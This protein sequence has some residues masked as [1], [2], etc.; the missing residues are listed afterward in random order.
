MWNDSLVLNAQQCS[1]YWIV[2]LCCLL[3]WSISGHPYHSC[4]HY[5]HHQV[6]CRQS[7]H[8]LQQPSFSA[9]L[10]LHLHLECTSLLL[11]KKVFLLKGKSLAANTPVFKDSQDKDAQ[12]ATKMLATALLAQ[13]DVKRAELDSHLLDEVLLTSGYTLL[14]YIGRRNLTHTCRLQQ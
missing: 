7:Y 5:Q 1:N 6:H 8:H 9:S 12:I 4:W 10:S 11:K 3:L 14:T 2:L 13:R